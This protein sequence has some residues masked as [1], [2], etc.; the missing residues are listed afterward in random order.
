LKKK[1]EKKYPVCKEGFPGRMQKRILPCCKDFHFSSYITFI[2]FCFIE[3]LIAFHVEPGHVKVVETIF[4]LRT[5][6][7][8][9]TVGL[10][11]LGQQLN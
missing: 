5:T 2:P 8:S 11:T 7:I 10:Q 1:K 6:A 3:D 9:L 4:N